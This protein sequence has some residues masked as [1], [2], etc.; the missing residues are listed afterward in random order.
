MPRKKSPGPIAPDGLLLSQMLANNLGMGCDF[1][2]RVIY[3][4]GEIEPAGAYRFVALFK[5]MDRFPGSIHVILN[6]P[7]GSI[8]N[9]Y[10]MYDT[11][12]TAE[13]P[14]IVEALGQV[15]S[16]A[17]PILLAGTVRFLNPQT[18]IMVHDL[19]YEIDGMVSSS[20]AHALSRDAKLLNKMYHEIIAERTGKSIKDVEEWCSKETNFTAAEAVKLGFADKVVD[21]RALPKSYEEGLKQLSGDEPAKP[22]KKRKK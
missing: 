14:V 11:I 17:V 5:W 3:I 9:G 12:R 19:S 18:M 8:S 7:G 15:A 21:T 4:F 6:S 22:K 1:E 10:A 16:A 2:N 20:V 13:N